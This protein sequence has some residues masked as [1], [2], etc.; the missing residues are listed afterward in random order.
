ML[1]DS[2]Y[3]QYP[4]RT[5][6]TVDL[7]VNYL[8]EHTMQT[9][10]GELGTSRVQYSMYPEEGLRPCTGRCTGHGR[11]I[12]CSSHEFGECQMP[13]GFTISSYPTYNSHLTSASSFS[14]SW[15]PQST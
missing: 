5:M 13:D 14:L 15:I 9:C 2:W 6:L 7:R 11:K 4:L 8:T 10:I 1:G 12:V 3:T